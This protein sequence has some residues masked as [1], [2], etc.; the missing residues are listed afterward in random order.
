MFA[1][2]KTF[3]ETKANYVNWPSEYLGNVY[4]C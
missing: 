1:V 4:V 2:M 3:H